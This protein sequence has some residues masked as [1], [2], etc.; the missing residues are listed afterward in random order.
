MYLCVMSLQMVDNSKHRRSAARGQ[1]KVVPKS[2]DESVLVAEF[3]RRK[4]VIKDTCEKY[5]AF[6]TREKLLAKLKLKPGPELSQGVETDDQLWA[7]LKKTSHH[8]FF[9]QKEHGL[10]W[11]KVPKAASTSWLH[12]FL[13]LAHVPDEEVPEDNGL[14]LHG[15]LRD[16]YPLLSKNLQRQFLP[17]SLKFVVVRHPFQRIMSAYVDKLQSYQRDLLYRGGYYYAMYGADIVGRYRPKYQ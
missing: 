9:V 17:K 4:K 15:F 5:G 6:T 16:K 8:Q 2:P 3:N 13:S 11:C 7:L 10:M 12:A 14:G 1:A